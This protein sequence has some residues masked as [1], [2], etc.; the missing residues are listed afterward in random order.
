MIAIDALVIFTAVVLLSHLYYS[1]CDVFGHKW[2]SMSNE[3][4]V[5]TKC[6]LLRKKVKDE[7]NRA[8]PS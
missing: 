3:L 7:K 8:K 2:E 4:D 1:R 6:G 5:C